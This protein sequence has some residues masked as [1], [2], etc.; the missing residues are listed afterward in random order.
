[1]LDL[2]G[3]LHVFNDFL[4]R[5][6]QSISAAR[7]AG[8]KIVLHY[9]TKL[10]KSN[11]FLEL[12]FSSCKC[13]NLVHSIKEICQISCSNKKTQI[14]S[15]PRNFFI[16]RPD[17]WHSTKKSQCFQNVFVCFMQKHGKVNKIKQNNFSQSHST[18]NV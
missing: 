13:N 8:L 11:G 12:Y 15:I 4:S 1:M 3:F 9:Y 10:R 18:K 16:P 5:L 17:M 14:S 7:K 6:S 2:I